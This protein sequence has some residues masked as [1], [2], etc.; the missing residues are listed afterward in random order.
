MV[1]HLLHRSR[2]IPFPASQRQGVKVLT[3][4]VR[5]TRY[6]QTER[7]LSADLSE[8]FDYAIATTKSNSGITAFA[9]R[10]GIAQWNPERRPELPIESFDSVLRRLE[11]LRFEFTASL[12]PAER[13][14]SSTTVTTKAF[15]IVLP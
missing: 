5:R 2:Q 15:Y 4:P 10:I 6:H 1:G 8:T 9:C 14:N 12:Q 3:T 7:R 11:A 13:L